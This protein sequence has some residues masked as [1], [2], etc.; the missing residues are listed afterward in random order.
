[1]PRFQS[2]LTDRAGVADGTMAFA[3]ERPDYFGFTA[4]Q[5]ITTTLPDPVYNDEKGNRRPNR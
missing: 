2:K 3:F 5:F 4:G 1:M